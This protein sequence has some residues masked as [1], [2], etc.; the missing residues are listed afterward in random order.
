MVVAA[1]ASYARRDREPDLQRLSVRGPRPDRLYTDGPANRESRALPGRLPVRPALGRIHPLAAGHGGCHPRAST[2]LG[3]LHGSSPDKRCLLSGNLLALA[4]TLRQPACRG[5]RGAAA[6]SPLHHWLDWNLHARRLPDP[7]R[8]RHAVRHRRSDLLLPRHVDVRCALLRNRLDSP[9]N[10]GSTDRVPVLPPMP[11]RR[12]SQRLA[13]FPQGVSGVDGLRWCSAAARTGRESGDGKPRHVCGIRPRLA[14]ECARGQQGRVSDCRQLHH[15]RL[16]LDDHDRF[17]SS[18][19]SL[20][21]STLA[22]HQCRPGTRAKG[23]RW[24]RR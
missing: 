4:R 9:S 14:R 10:H 13:A 12:S 20:A 23:Q 6:S 21:R 11:H 17:A 19:E 1:L 7:P 24:E 15:G 22:R 18:A 2:R 3:V 5:P 8:H 16:F